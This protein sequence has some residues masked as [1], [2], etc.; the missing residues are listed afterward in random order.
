MT[1]KLI[2]LIRGQ[3]P[4]EPSPADMQTWNDA[5]HDA[6]LDDEIAAAMQNE[7]VPKPKLAAESAA[8]FLKTS[9]EK[10]ANEQSIYEQQIADLSERL[11]QIKLT[12]KAFHAA[13]GTIEEDGKQREARM[14]QAVEFTGAVG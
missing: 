13:L 11:R 7:F 9:L 2:Q 14:P 4:L 1:N 3:Q 8:D 10:L 12:A 6:S 5:A